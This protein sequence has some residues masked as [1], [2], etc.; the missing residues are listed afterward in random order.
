MR[1]LPRAPQERGI[2]IRPVFVSV[3]IMEARSIFR[4]ISP[5]DHRYS[6]SEEAL[7]ESLSPWLSEE[8]SI[9]ACVRAEL[10]LVIAHLRLRAREGASRGVPAEGG[11][12]RPPDDWPLCAQSDM[13]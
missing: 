6:I 7:F 9:A 8:A 13:G 5:I 2:D 4:N 1:K 3:S 10:A 12:G 11:S